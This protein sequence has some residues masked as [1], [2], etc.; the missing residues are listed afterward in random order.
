MVYKCFK[1]D[2]VVLRVV[3]KYPKWQVSQVDMKITQWM[4][5]LMIT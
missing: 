1:I 3:M 4:L 2:C 5:E